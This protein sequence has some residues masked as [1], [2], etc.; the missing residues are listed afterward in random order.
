MLED[1]RVATLR[2]HR[3]AVL[4]QHRNDLV[5]HLRH[6]RIRLGTK[7]QLMNEIHTTGAPRRPEPEPE[8]RE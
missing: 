6:D 1:G 4:H 3:V 5:E 2:H 7:R 8:Q